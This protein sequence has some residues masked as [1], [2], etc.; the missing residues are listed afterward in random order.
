[1]ELDVTTIIR[2]M[3]DCY[4]SYMT[5]GENAG[6]ITWNNAVDYASDN[7]VLTDQDQIDAVK[8]HIKSFGAWSESEINQW[9]I[10]ELNA[11]FC[12]L[13]ISEYKESGLDEGRIFESEGKF[14]YYCG[15]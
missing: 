13:V 1:M 10:T 15:E 6:T 4:G 3:P 8:R 5:H 9:S 2:D 7:A 11:L 14:Y 12:Q